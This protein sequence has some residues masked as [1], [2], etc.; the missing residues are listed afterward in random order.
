M[1]PIFFE[2]QATKS[3]ENAG[4]IPGNAANPAPIS[5]ITLCSML[6]AHCPTIG[7]EEQKLRRSEGERLRS[8]EVGKIKSD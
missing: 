5:P 2:Y 3:L 6:Y 8:W 7:K 1:N 4:L